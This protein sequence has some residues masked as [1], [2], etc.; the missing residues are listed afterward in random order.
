MQRVIF[1]QL[2][3][4]VSCT[5][6]YLLGCSATKQAL[7]ID[8]VLETVERDLELVQELGLKL[9][10][11]VNTH[12]HADHVTGSG[13][14]KCHLNDGKSSP[15]ESVISRVSGAKAD[16]LVDENDV[17]T[18][19]QNIN[20]HVLCTPGHTSGCITLV[21]HVQ[22]AAF[23]GDSLMIRACGRTDFQEGSPS[24]LYQSVHEKIF[25]LAE[26]YK[27]YPAHDYKGRTVTTVGE[28]KQFNPR[29]TKS[30]DEFIKIMENLN[31]EYPKMIDVAVPRNLICG[32]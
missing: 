25:K 21:D 17:I 4:R 9:R 24:A 7:L 14:I 20:L 31:L 6:T 13:Q 32:L 18:C 26:H 16:I 1:R 2:F 30:R 11:L 3:D 8:P 15:V 22:E 19:G 27:I 10:Y 23:T 29:L 12:V 5:Y 28:E